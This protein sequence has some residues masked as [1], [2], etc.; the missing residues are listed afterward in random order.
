MKNPDNSPEMVEPDVELIF[1][2]KTDMI[3]SLTRQKW[4][5]ITLKVDFFLTVP[6]SRLSSANWQ[7]LRKKW[8]RELAEIIKQT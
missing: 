3:E 5:K 6:S 2:D 8:I 4:T 1:E 7:R